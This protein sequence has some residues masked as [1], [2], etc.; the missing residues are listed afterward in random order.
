MKSKFI[1]T[2]VFFLILLNVN[3]IASESKVL[4]IKTDWS[5]KGIFGKFDRGELRRGYQ[6]YSEVC[7]GCHSISQLSYRNLSEKGGPEFSIKVVEDIA[8]SFEIKDGPNSE[9]D[10]FTRPGRLPDKFP[11][12]YPNIE[13]AK[14]ANGGAYPPDMSVLAKARKGGAA[15]IFSLLQGYNEPPEGYQ[16]DEGVYYNKYMD[17]NQIKMPNVLFDD[18]VEYVDGTKATKEQMSKD[19]SSFLTWVSEPSLESRHKLG[20]KVILFLI[21]LAVLVYFSMNRLWSRIESK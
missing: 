1:L 11:N 16:L 18:L 14:A 20:F 4:F 13:A 7:S 5:F 6:V 8:A 2:L 3:L 17:G 19:I 9:G 10:M 12:P 21:I 15:Y